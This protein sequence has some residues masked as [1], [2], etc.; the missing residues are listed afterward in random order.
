[1]KGHRGWRW[2][3]PPDPER[4]LD[5]ELKFHIEQRTRDYIAKGM[6]AEA[7]RDA[8]T[9]RLGDVSGVREACTS[10][11]AAER[12]AEGR[13][14]MLRVSWLDVKLGLR[15]F[16]RY[17]G[18]SLVT[19]VGMAVAIAIAAGYFAAFGTMLDSNLP[20]DKEGRVVVIRTRALAGQPGLGAGASMH[21]FEEWQR[22]LKSIGD[23]GAFREDSRNLITGDG[24][25]YLVDVASITASGLP[26]TGDAPLLGRTLLP[27]DE[28]AMAPPV[29]VIAYDE[30]QRRFTGDAGILGRVVRLD[31]TPHTIVG[32]M[33]Q[34]FGFPINHRYW[35]PLRPTDTDRTAGAGVWVNV[36]GR[37][38]PGFS[39]QDAQSEVAA[40]GERM[41]VALPDTHEEIRPQV[42]SYTHTFIGTE[43]PEA[44]LAVRGLQFGVCLLLLIV[45]VNVSILVYARTAT[46][47]GEI[48]VRTA[49]GASRSRVVAQLF[50]EAL[51]PAI[52]A[53]ALGLGV[54]SI[55]FR[56]FREYIA[57]S[58][59]RI[60][61][62]ITPESFRVTPGVILYAA[63]LATFSALIIGVLPALKATG[64]RVQ[65]G[66]QQFS[67]RG[68]GMQLGGTWTALI[69]LQVAITV[70]ALPAALYNAEAGYRVGLR[71]PATAAAPLL[72]ATVNM[73]RDMSTRTDQGKMGA[74][75]IASFKVRMSALLQKLE[76]EPGISAVTYAD[77]FPG[78][79][80]YVTFEAEPETRGGRAEGQVQPI[81]I[82]TRPSR[83]AQ[84]FF[85]VLGVRTLAG[86]GFTAGDASPG[87]NTVI[88]DQAFAE[89]LGPGGSVLGRRVRLS[90]KSA[91]GTVEHDP[92]HEIVGVVPAFADGMAPTVSI[93]DP[94]PRLYLAARPGDNLP[95]TVII[96]VNGGDPTRL[97]QRLRE[98]SVSVHPTLKLEDVLGVVQDFDHNRQAFWYVSLGVMTVTAS[99]LLLSA[100]GIYAM[101]SFTV[102]KRRREI[103]IRAALGADARRVLLGIFGRASAQ[104]GAGVAAGLVLASALEWLG[105]DF[106]GGKGHIL[107]PTVAAVMFTV[108][109]LAA[110]GPA[111]RGLAVQ[112]TEALREE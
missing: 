18:L 19:V 22:E 108:G 74:E 56:W 96:Q 60:P 71:A 44:E 88:V 97:S 25:A 54:V 100:A 63:A 81:A 16:A 43:G 4:E 58:S 111:R 29:L 40:L 109:I 24:Q 68:A 50:V 64:R 8:A 67:A 92:W 61:Y 30:W 14:T 5:E 83:V 6:T 31:E 1:M 49:L 28:R 26:F 90:K 11:L 76:A 93:G 104:I 20:F 42:Q 95:A 9:R 65:L 98:I 38:A 37:I 69:V 48:A 79:E 107:L 80:G 91:D 102:A 72:R 21:D 53:A 62:W 110:L 112:P 85:E 55:A 10:V 33:P 34:G 70:A 17:P 15:M 46:R 105:G 2:I 84:N 94:M 47:S 13:R 87:A 82:G 101:M 99:V 36:F 3:F 73:S 77:R 35:V 86:R 78:Q 66:L 27:E 103:G 57:N 41:A 51:V 32:V 59:E 89:R 75:V 106:M 12:A 23:L 45:A 7:A 39:L 52:T